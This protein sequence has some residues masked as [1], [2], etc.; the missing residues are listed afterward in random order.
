MSRNIYDAI[1]GVIELTPIM[2]DLIETFEL[3]RLR[4]IRQ[5]G[6]TNLVFPGANHT[7]FEHSLGVGHLARKICTNLKLEKDEENMIVAAALLHDI[8]HGP[9]S[10]YY[11]F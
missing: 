11:H 7:R 5:L 9:Y 6:V 8:G 1:H 2:K 4:K 10:N 3:Q